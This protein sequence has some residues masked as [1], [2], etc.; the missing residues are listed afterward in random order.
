MFFFFL[1]KS[2]SLNLFL[3]KTNAW[4]VAVHGKICTLYAVDTVKFI[5]NERRVFQKKQIKEV[6]EFS[7]FTSFPFMM[8]RVIQELLLTRSSELL[9]NVTSSQKAKSHWFSPMWLKYPP[10][11]TL[12]NNTFWGIHS[13]AYQKE[14]CILVAVYCC[15]QTD[16][17]LN[18]IKGQREYRKIKNWF[19]KFV[20]WS[21]QIFL[22][23]FYFN[24]WS[25]VLQ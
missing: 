18:I 13:F 16:V 23:I 22:T 9:K 25:L 7:D 2:A 21:F 12:F 24:I 11:M 4:Q 20:L 15:Y 19:I 6:F 1:V 8:S 17:T 3:S 14:H 10:I 5:I